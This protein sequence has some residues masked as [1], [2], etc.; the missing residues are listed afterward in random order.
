MK[1]VPRRT[2]YIDITS[3][4]IRGLVDGE[5]CFTFCKDW[6]KNYIP[7]FGIIMHARDQWLL[8][9]VADYLNIK[10]EVRI[11]RAYNYP[12]DPIKHPMTA[13]MMVRDIE[14]LKNVV[15]PIFYKRLIGYKGQQFEG[16]MERIGSD[17]LVPEK[18]KL[19]Y[20]LYKSGYW[21][22]KENYIDEKFWN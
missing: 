22:K 12:H 10:G 19:L 18:Y 11:Y 3:E 13:R 2:N 15:V 6:F 8:V 14:T 9:K 5:G 17:P 20:R 21:D 16:W 4:Y 1:D 7:A